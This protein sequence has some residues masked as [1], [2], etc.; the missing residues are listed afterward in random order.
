MGQNGQSGE[1]IE[2]HYMFYDKT[3][4]QNRGWFWWH[5]SLS[6]DNAYTLLRE[7]LQPKF[8]NENPEGKGFITFLQKRVL[9]Q[10]FPR[11]KDEKNRDHWVL[12]LAW[13]QADLEISELWS[14][15]DN[16]V[17]KHV[18]SGQD[19]VPEELSSFDYN[20]FYYRLTHTGGEGSVEQGKEGRKLVENAE[21][22][23][24][25]NV[26]FYCERSNGRAEIITQPRPPKV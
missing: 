25:V 24:M 1:V 23:G 9:F 18:G 6:P 10:Y 3:K 7:K 12:L 21:R 26:T 5:H 11:N 15:F 19:D 13:P 16:G 14:I 17:F 22:I 4:E 8:G 2:T 20:P